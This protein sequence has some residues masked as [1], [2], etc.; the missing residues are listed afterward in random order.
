M[1]P[2]TQPELALSEAEGATPSRR[3]RDLGEE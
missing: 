1:T 2:L 3:E